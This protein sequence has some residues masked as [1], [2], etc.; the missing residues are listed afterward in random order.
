MNR[1][2]SESFSSSIFILRKERDRQTD[3]E[4]DRQKQRETGTENAHTAYAVG[5]IENLY[6]STHAH[7]THTHT[8]ARLA[9]KSKAKDIIAS[10][11]GKERHI[12]SQQVD[13]LHQKCQSSAI[14]YLHLFYT[15]KDCSIKL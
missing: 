11:P 4:T 7:N 14:N 1:G 9:R 3:R 5:L 15:E 12:K 2:I 13:Y 8:H 10:R 6:T